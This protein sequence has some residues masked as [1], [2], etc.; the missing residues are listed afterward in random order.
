MVT[1]SKPLSATQAAAYHAEEFTNAEQ[2]YYSQGQQVRGEWQ[3]KLAAEWGLQGAVTEEAFS[4]LAAGQHPETGEQLIRHTQA[5]ELV[6]GD[7]TVTKTMEHRAGRDATFSAPKTVSLAA[8]VGGDERVRVAHREAV[9]TALDEM[10]RYVQAR[11]GGNAPAETTAKWAVAKFEHDT[12]RPVDGYAAPQLHTHAVFFNVTET[13]DGKAYSVQPQELY[14]TQ[15]YATAVYQ[16]ELASKLRGLGYEIEA[17]KTGAPEIKGFSQEYVEAMSPRRQQIEEHLDAE[18]KHG[19]AAAQ[20]A[21]H[22]TR[23]AKEPL[24]EEETLRR[25]REMAAKYG[26]Q[27]AQVVEATKGRNIEPRGQARPA[28]SAM[29]FARD[30]NMEREAVVDERAMMRDALKRSMGQATFAEVK[31]HFNERIARGEFVEV[32]AKIGRNVTTPEMIALERSNIE[33]MKEGQGRYAPLAE[34]RWNDRLSVSQN[35]AVQQVLESRDQVTGLQGA[36]GAGKTTSLAALREAVEQAGYTVEGFA[37]TSRAAYQ[38]EEAGIK[39]TTLQ[40]HLVKSASNGNGAKHLYIVDESSLASS[41][42]IHEFLQRL[43]ENDRVLLVGDTRQHQAVD[44]GRP[45]EQLQQAGMRTARLDEIIRQKDE[46]LKSTVEQLARG[47]VREAVEGMREQGRVHEIADPRERVAAIAAEYARTPES[48]LVIS[49]DNASRMSLNRAIHRE[50]QERGV[51]SG[52]EHRVTVLVARQEMT[53]ADRAW[54][55]RY[56]LGDVLRYSK[57]SQP[58][59]IEA[60]EYA[61]VVEIDGGKNRLTVEREDGEQVTYDPR[62]L[63]GVTVYRE[64][65][66]NFAE[67]DRVQ[68]TAPDKGNR[69]ANRELGTIEEI[70]ADGQAR[71]KLDSG[72]EVQMDLNESA[73]LDY[74]YAVT[75][76]SS[77]GATAD[78]VLIHIDSETA[79]ANLLNSRL[80]YVAVS[81]ARHDAQIFTNDAESLGMK[82]DRDHSHS[83]AVEGM[84]Q[85]PAAAAAGMGQSQAG[86]AQVPEEAGQ[87]LA[88]EH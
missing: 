69:I 7:G 19:A 26:N 70:G 11:I 33:R 59:Q 1:I 4:S 14:R 42:Q 80:A 29:T 44:A 21:A 82:L 79:G 87:A 61:R 54:A 68:F 5:R 35:Q 23:D 2:S 15:Q 74:G 78:R 27:P 31:A 8:L 85:E 58:M 62:R 56:E 84:M 72:R 57:G 16:S 86:A 28:Q 30:R 38:L 40:H 6:S 20:I 76:H 39:A 71:V 13:A 75:S 66:R 10:E 41:Q 65:E 12:A 45:F 48:T 49:P 32:A 43:K 55:A 24:S 9:T 60:G 83:A 81:R 37:P 77:Q 36:A 67:G 88:M 51:V 25:H 22:R 34:P 47:E 53:G 50:M 18:G 52:E 3:G 46:A 64:S 73:H 63:Q 17:G